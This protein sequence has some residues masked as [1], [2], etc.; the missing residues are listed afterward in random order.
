MPPGNLSAVF[1]ALAD[2]ARR[3]ILAR[4][5]GQEMSV[6]ALA[7]PMR[8]SLPAV[9]KHLKVLERAGLIARSRDGQWR[10]CRLEAEALVP[11]VE[12]LGQFALLWAAEPPRRKRRPRA[13]S[14][15]GTARRARLGLK[16]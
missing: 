7:A 14:G 2:P 16:P 4:L 15:D 9:S 1:A 3:S 12:W 11:A 6:G 5:A 8:I 10:P 13:P